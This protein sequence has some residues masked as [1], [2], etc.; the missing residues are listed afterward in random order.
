M[1][2]VRCFYIRKRYVEEAHRGLSSKSLETLAE[3]KAENTIDAYEADWLDFCDWCRYRRVEA[4]PPSPDVIV[5]Y[6]NDLAAYAKFA[7]IRRRVSALSEN[8]N[9]AGLSDK[10]PCRAWVVRETLIG[11][12][13]SMGMAQKGKTPIY[14]EELQRI[15]AQMDDTKLTDVRDKA[16]LLLGFLGAFRRSEMAQFGVSDLEFV[17][18]GVIVTVRQ[19]KTDQA[20]VG[21]RVAIPYLAD[22]A[23]C[24]VLALRHWLSAACITEGALFR[25]VSRAG[26]VSQTGLSDK[27]VNLIVKR[28]VG[29]IGLDPELYGAHSLRHGFAT[30]AALSGVEERIIMKQTRHRSVEMVRRYI[31]EADLFKNNPISMMFRETGMN[32]SER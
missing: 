16:V 7:T 13:R 31:E 18:Q 6:V 2:L 11:L 10:N 26:R 3:T 1:D 32:G 12:S 22:E 8:F 19:S 4:F 30:Y 27:S 20:G 21:Q 5:N 9:A 17:P 15:F 23:M 24:G 28:R 25:R 29:D 14:W